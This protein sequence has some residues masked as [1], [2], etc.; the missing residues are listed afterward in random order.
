MYR[1]SEQEDT[2][3]VTVQIP[4]E[5]HLKMFES[6]VKCYNDLIKCE[7]IN[8]YEYGGMVVAGQEI[9]TINVEF[10]DWSDW[11]NCLQLI[12]GSLTKQVFGPLETTNVSPN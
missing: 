2:L 6:A 7:A 3:T 8:I 11:N 9:E 4:S 10:R 5:K 1:V 12:I